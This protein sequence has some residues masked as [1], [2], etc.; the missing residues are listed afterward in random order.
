VTGIVTSSYMTQFWW[1]LGAYLVCYG[2]ALALRN[3]GE[4][5]KM[6][7]T[8]RA[9]GIAFMLHFV[10]ALGVTTHWFMYNG[11]NFNR[12]ALFFS[13]Y[14]TAVLA[15]FVLVLFQFTSSRNFETYDEPEQVEES[16][17]NP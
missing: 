17:Q 9:W 12:F 2:V 16:S 15:D 10:I 1:L 3:R 6:H 11:I 8:R 7:S 4:Y 13:F 5:T 14:A